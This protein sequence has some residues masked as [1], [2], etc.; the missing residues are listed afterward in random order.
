MEEKSSG[1]VDFPLMD[2][3]NEMISNTAFREVHRTGSRFTWTNKQNPPIMCV[4]DRVLISNT[5]E[6]KFNLVSVMT[7]PR[8]GSDHNPLVVDTGGIVE[9]Q[10]H[11]FRFSS[12]WIKQIGF[13]DWVRDK[14]PSR[15]KRDPLGHWHIISGKL[16]RAIKGWGIN[17][18]SHQKKL[19]RTF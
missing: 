5:W 14:W 11:Y 12:H 13:C 10:Q 9:L 2:A 1:N 19:N 15:Y 7:A 8:L 3:F 18:D 4:L 6:D 17:V 16:R